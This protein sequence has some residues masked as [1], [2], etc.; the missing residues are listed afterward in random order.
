MRSHMILVVV[1]QHRRFRTCQKEEISTIKSNLTRQK[2][3]KTSARKR[4][5]AC[6]SPSTLTDQIDSFSETPAKRVWSNSY[7]SSWNLANNRIH[8]SKMDSVATERCLIQILS[9][10]PVL[11]LPRCPTW[12]RQLCIFQQIC[13]IHQAF[14]HFY[15]FSG[16]SALS[17]AKR[18]LWTSG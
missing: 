14:A 5:S 16:W 12:T 13:E 2:K 18:Y 9:V 8:A 4:I 7:I 10:C 6:I 17:K 11:C 1:Y 3:T 15:E